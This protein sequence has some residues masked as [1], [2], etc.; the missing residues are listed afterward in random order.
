MGG[1]VRADGFRLIAH[2]YEDVRMIEGRQ[3]ADTHEFLRPDS[4]LGETRLVV[5]MWCD[6]IG[7][8]D[9]P[10]LFSAAG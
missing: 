4:H 7:H 6:V 3:S 5:K 8:N 10:R 2:V 1:A 9:A